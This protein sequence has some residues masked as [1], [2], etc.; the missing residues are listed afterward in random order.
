MHDSA[1]G[2]SKGFGFIQFRARDEAETALKE[3]NGQQIF[4]SIFHSSVINGKPIKLSY[5]SARR[6]LREDE[7]PKVGAGKEAKYDVIMEGP[8]IPNIRPPP[9]TPSMI[10]KLMANNSTGS[11]S[12]LDVYGNAYENPMFSYDPVFRVFFK[13][14]F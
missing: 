2:A 14:D 5:A 7:T 10:A 12:M 11:A 1:T 6:W 4:L 8:E 3:M 13:D 9:P